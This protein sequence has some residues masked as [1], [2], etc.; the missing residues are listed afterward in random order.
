MRPKFNNLGGMKKRKT[1]IFTSSFNIPC[2]LSIIPLPLLHSIFLVHCSLFKS[3][4]ALVGVST[5]QGLKIQH[6]LLIMHYSKV[7][8]NT[9]QLFLYVGSRSFHQQYSLQQ[10]LH[11]FLPYLLPVHAIYPND[12]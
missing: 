1:P 10:T 7:P 4:T 12:I 3:S 11:T 8:P 9:P 2:S 6:S 5:D